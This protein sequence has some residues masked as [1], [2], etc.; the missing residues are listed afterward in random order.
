ME[1]NECKKLGFGCMRFPKLGEE[2]DIEQVKRMF[3]IFMEAGFTY[4]DTAHVYHSG[5]SELVV[6]ECLTERY[7]REKFMLTTKLSTWNFQKEEDIIP[8]FNEQLRDTGVEYFDYYLM[9]AQDREEYEK[10]KKCRAYEIASE[11]KEQGKIKHIGISFHDS[12]EVLR[13]ILTEQP[14]IEAVQI[15]FNY[16]D[17]LNPEVDGKGVYRVCREFGKDIIIM[18]PVKGGY[19]ANLPDEAKETLAVAG[20][21]S[22]ASY[23]VR[24]AA[25]FEGV[26]MVLSGM[27]D[28]A[29]VE[30]NVATMKDFQPLSE[31]EQAVIEKTRDLLIGMNRIECTACRYC[32]D[33]CPMNIS[34]PDIFALYNSKT[35]Y[36]NWGTEGEYD[37][38][39]EKGGK[40]C[41]CIECGQCESA[42]PQHLPVIEL[43]KKVSEKYDNRDKK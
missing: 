36:K 22:P 11:L 39:T 21:G 2:I 18:E 30:D 20:E 26:K 41:E 12:A 28:I 17:Y 32:T 29:Q 40:A 37:K 6:R 15:Q 42:C 25:G 24:Y 10:Y 38:L 31:E 7:P 27:S 3:D 8:L 35:C 33:G 4:F 23:A 14:T 5:K 16:V 13:K 1:L 43:L 19:L 34:I 9:H